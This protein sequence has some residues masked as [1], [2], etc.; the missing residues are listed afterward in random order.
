MVLGA[1]YDVTFN[2]GLTLWCEELR[3]AR[4]PTCLGFQERLRLARPA[5]GCTQ[6]GGIVPPRALRVCGL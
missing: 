2:P 6:P 4:F 3:E 1:A 5:W